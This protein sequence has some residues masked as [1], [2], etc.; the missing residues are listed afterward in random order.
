MSKFDYNGT[1]AERLLRGTFKTAT[2]WFWIGAAD[3]KGYGRLTFHGR[4]RLAHQVAWILSNGE[5]PSSLFVL[6]R[7]DTPQCV[8]PEHLFLGTYADNS[9]DARSKGSDPRLAESLKPRCKRGHLLSGR[10]MYVNPCSGQRVCRICHQQSSNE[11]K[12]THYVGYVN[13]IPCYSK[14]KNDRELHST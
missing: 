9:K 10:N 13:G 14:E 6:H 5:I 3:P 1:P 12:R 2:C 8:N 7:C 4:N 11:W